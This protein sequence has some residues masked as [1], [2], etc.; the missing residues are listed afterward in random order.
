MVVPS[1]A[2]GRAEDE[3]WLMALVTTRGGGASHLL[4]LDAG[5]VAAGPVA[6]VH[7][8]RPV[9]MGF[10]GAWIDDTDLPAR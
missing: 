6:Q 4:V 3:G 2:P 8:P 7:L 9:P 10:H 1:T 5:D